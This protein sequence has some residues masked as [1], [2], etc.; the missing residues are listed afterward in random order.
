MIIQCTKCHIRKYPKFFYTDKRRHNTRQPCKSCISRV[1]REI[2][3]KEPW[4]PLFWRI[5]SKCRA[6]Y[7]KGIECRFIHYNEIKRLWLKYNASEMKQPS[8]DRINNNDHYYTNNCQ[9]IER[10]ENSR[11]DKILKVPTVCLR[12]DKE[13]SV[14]PYRLKTAKYCSKKCRAGKRL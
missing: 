7:G 10:G 11:K 3:I 4:K 14:I 12:C 13:F 2:K 8:I 6:G 1:H 5:K 9:F